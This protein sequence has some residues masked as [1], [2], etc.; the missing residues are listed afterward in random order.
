MDMTELL[1]KAKESAKNRTDEERFQLLVDAKILTK[2]GHFDPR[3][4]SKETVRKS[5]LA[6][7]NKNN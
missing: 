1:R 3:F 7:K 4:F 2:E 6:L 5:K